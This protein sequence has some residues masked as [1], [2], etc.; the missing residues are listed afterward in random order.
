ML[1]ATREVRHRCLHLRSELQSQMCWV[2]G[3]GS[4][5]TACGYGHCPLSSMWLRVEAHMGSRMGVPVY[6][7][8]LGVCGW[9]FPGFDGKDE[10]SI[11]DRAG[12]S[13]LPVL[14]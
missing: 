3:S 5:G 11:L 14:A 2:S 7:R 8:V 1:D 6:V 10:V 4:A 9:F 13:F 12:L